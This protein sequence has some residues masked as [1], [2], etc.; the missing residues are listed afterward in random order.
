MDIG[1]ILGPL[2]AI[3]CIAA[4]MAAKGALDLMPQIITNIPSIMIVIGGTM[5]ALFVGYPIKDFMQ[6][7]TDLKKYFSGA[8]IDKDALAF[9]IIDLA[10]IAR[11]ES[12]LSLEKK[13]EEID[14]E[15]LKRAVRMAVDGTDA[16]IIR[17]SLENERHYEFEEAE[18]AIKFWEDFGAIAP[19]IGILGAVIGLMMVM[20]IL[21][22]PERIGGGIAV[23]FIA[24]IWGV[25]AANI[26]GIPVAKRLKRIASTDSHARDMVVIG[27]EGI[28]NGLN[29]KVINNKLEIYTSADKLE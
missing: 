8:T 23:A 16:N 19:T 29:P 22:Q 6:G 7:F 28:L 21:D 4:G 24:T 26:W 3:G 13:V 15:P 9:E 27:I 20:Q 11:K 18:V 10:N 2:L 17:E 12:I 14:Y 1:A 5:G 25:G